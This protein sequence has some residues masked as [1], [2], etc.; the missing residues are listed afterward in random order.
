MIQYWAQNNSRRGTSFS[1][2]S[3][4]NLALWLD[5][6]D[7]STFT[8]DGSNN[9]EQW[10][11]KSG[12]GRHVNQSTMANRPSYVTGVLN[13]LPV[14]RPDGINDWLESDAQTAA[15]WYGSGTQQ[16]T[17]MMLLGL[18]V[19]DPGKNNLIGGLNTSVGGGTNRLLIERQPV[20]IGSTDAVIT[21]GGTSQFITAAPQAGTSWFIETIRWTNAGTPTL[22][23]TNTAGTNT[24]NGLGTLTG[25]MGA[26]QRAIVGYGATLAANFNLAEELIF[27]RNISDAE[28]AQVETAWL[29]KWGTI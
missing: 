10:R 5:A 23:R 14:V 21:A 17:L 20:G 11:D 13:G 18:V 7:A 3:I 6:A 29:A 25:T 22:R 19:Q 8:L 1:P 15:T 28:V 2:T 16:V 12:G 27:A 9:V 4:P 24:Y 26:N